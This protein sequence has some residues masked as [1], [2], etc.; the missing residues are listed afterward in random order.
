MSDSNFKENPQ[1]VL[2]QGTLGPATVTI[3]GAKGLRMSGLTSFH[4]D[5]GPDFAWLN[6]YRTLAA[7]RQLEITRER[8]PSQVNIKDGE[9]EIRWP[10]CDDVQGERF[11]MAVEGLVEPE[12]N[13]QDAY[14]FMQ[15]LDALYDSAKTGDKVEI[16]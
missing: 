8:E 7:G 13:A 15:I 12:V 4:L 2:T 6:I 3:L 11:A 1:P 14:Q 10:A 5:E 9:V 16:E